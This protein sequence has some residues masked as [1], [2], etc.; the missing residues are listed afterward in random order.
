MLRQLVIT[1]LKEARESAGL[2]QAKLARRL[3]ITA[4]AI[5]NYESGIREPPMD[6]C[7]RWAEACGQCLHLVVV[8]PDVLPAAT[9]PARDRRLIEITSELSEEDRRLVEDFAR[10]LKGGDPK[11][12]EMI[13]V[14][15]P[16]L[17]KSVRSSSESTGESHVN[18]G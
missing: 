17:L 16:V 10:G 7:A 15:I 6:L 9:L 2:S 1:R 11:L 4:A 5:G 8:G 18:E 12:R 13:A 3:G 14:Q